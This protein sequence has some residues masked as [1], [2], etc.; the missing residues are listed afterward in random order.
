MLLVSPSLEL[1]LKN[2]GISV[3]GELKLWEI[4]APEAYLIADTR[5][6]LVDKPEL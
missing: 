3:G 2:Q 6:V 5:Y 4:H 1:Q